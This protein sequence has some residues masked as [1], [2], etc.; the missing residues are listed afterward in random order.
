MDVNRT[1]ELW[2]R[3]QLVPQKPRIL[4]IKITYM[5]KFGRKKLSTPRIVRSLKI[6]SMLSGDNNTKL[7]SK[8]N[9]SNTSVKQMWW[10][11]NVVWSM[12]CAIEVINQTKTSWYNGAFNKVRLLECKSCSNEKLVLKLLI[13]N[14]TVNSSL[15]GIVNKTYHI[16]FE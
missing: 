8:L 4:N 13:F 3:K 9:N 11:S 12:G 7:K 6:L 5:K 16:D 14:R 1:T 15:I 2:C 10:N